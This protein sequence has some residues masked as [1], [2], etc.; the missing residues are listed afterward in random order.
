MKTYNQFCGV[1]K[2]LDVLGE[3]WTVLLVRDLLLGPRRYSELLAGLPGLTTNLLAQRLKHLQAT[4]IVQKT[5]EG[6][7]AL[8]DMGRELETVVLSLG[9]FGAR[10]LTRPADGEHTNLRWAMVSLKRRYRRSRLA[11]VLAVHIGAEPFTLRLGGQ[12]LEI[13]DGVLFS[14]DASLRCDRTTWLALYQGTT[15][16]TRAVHQGTLHVDGDREVVEDFALSVG[17]PLRPTTPW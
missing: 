9:Q 14:P 11:R 1:A 3:R 4:G 16:I 17:I 10:Y 6:A 8:T 2:A 13:V 12:R 5:A 15:T 7:Y